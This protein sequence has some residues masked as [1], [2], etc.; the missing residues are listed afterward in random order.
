MP[1]HGESPVLE[2]EHSIDGKNLDLYFTVKNFPLSQEKGW[3]L[4]TF[5]GKTSK[6]YAKQKRFSGLKSGTHQI[7]A[8][9]EQ[10]DG[11]R[12]PNSMIQFDV[13]IP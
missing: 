8:V 4:L 9:L 1:V 5:D 6:V 7:K 12:Y 2:V 10:K 13:N 3:V 11:V